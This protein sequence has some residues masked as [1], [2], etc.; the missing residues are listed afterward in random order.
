MAEMITLEMRKEEY[1]KYASDHKNRIT[2]CAGTGCMAN[3]SMKIY[4]RFREIIEE[5]GLSV[6]VA[7]EK[8]RADYSLVKSGCQGFCQ[9]G[10]LITLHTQGMMYTKVQLTDVEEIVDKTLIN[11]E[12][13]ERLLYRSPSD[14]VHIKDKNRIPFYS[15]QKRLMLDMCGHIDVRSLDEYILND[16]YFMARKAVLEMSDKEIC[17]EILE[18]GLRGRGGA[19]FLT[20]E[21]WEMA[22]TQVSDQRYV[23]CNGDEG[24]PGA[25]I[26]RCAME[27]N[28]HAIIEGMIIAASAINASEGYIYVRME[29][30][31]AVQRLKHAITAARTAGFLGKNIFGSNKNLEITVM[32]GAGAFVCGE[33]TALIASIEGRRGRPEIKPPYPT[34]KGLFGKP[35]VINNVETLATVPVILRMGA[36]EYSKIGT[37]SSK[38]TKTF[39]LTGHVANTGLIEVPFGTTLRE[40]VG[41]IGGGV[42]D[43]EGIC[44]Y[45][46]KA[47]QI[48]GP[49]GGCLTQQHLDLPLDYEHLQTVNAMMG[50]GGLVV[51]NQNTCMVEIARFFM[52]FTE[53]ESCGKCVV[54][55]EGTRQMRSLLDDIIEGRATEET[56]TLLEDLAQVVKVGSLCA[57]GKNAPNP[58]LSTLQYFRDEYLAHILEKRC[59]TGNCEALSHKA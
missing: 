27:G 39:A 12:C 26:D 15:K 18:S 37:E 57:L 14:G 35:T 48:G 44:G 22:R 29:Y 46:F 31:L 51:M 42:T 58:V 7:L 17:G 59:P 1:Q 4:E 41:D 47:V 30:P 45:D 43:D 34:K 54:C 56:L 36:D 23:I 19:G 52:K 25:F 11:G 20:G 28:P 5:R 49:S 2:I 55:R 10:P 53:N 9:M 3:G 21:K 8:E 38:G 33:E 16:G 6:T 40:I 24:D 13:I 32:E 50:S